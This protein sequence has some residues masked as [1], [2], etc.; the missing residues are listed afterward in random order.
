MTIYVWFLRYDARWTVF[1]S[2]WTI[3]Y[4]FTPI[5]TQ[6]KILK[7]WK[8]AH[9]DVIILHKCNKNHYHM[10]FCSW[11][12]VH[13][14]CNYYFSFCT[15]FALLPTPPPLTA[16]KIKI[17]QKSK[18]QLE[19]SSFYM[20]SKNYGQMMYSSWDMVRDRR[21]DGWKKWH[22]EVGAPPK[23]LAAFAAIFLTCVRP[24]WNM[25]ERVNL[26]F[27]FYFCFFNEFSNFYHSFFWE[28]FIK[29][30]IRV[31]YIVFIL[32]VS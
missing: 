32:Y 10:L 1:L 27:L 26:Y 14:R 7:N 6:I 29:H 28:F 8:K 19:A 11:D 16:Q 13:D 2:L 24:F 30:F 15:L 20:C 22:I 9:G 18:K 4:P 5:T 23:N 25:Y 31:I 21:T 3:F 17:L 12:M